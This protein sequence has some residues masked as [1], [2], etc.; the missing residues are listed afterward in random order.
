MK[1]LNFKNGSVVFYVTTSLFSRFC[2]Y[3]MI[4]AISEQFFA[5]PQNKAKKKKPGGL[6]TF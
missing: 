1:G 4:G 2:E 6:L 5:I 3:L